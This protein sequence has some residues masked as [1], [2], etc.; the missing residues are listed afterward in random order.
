ME[1]CA[2]LR[3]SASPRRSTYAGELLDAPSTLPIW[4]AA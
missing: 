4:S 2:Q 1:L 3:L